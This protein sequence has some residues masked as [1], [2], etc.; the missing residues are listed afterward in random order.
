V[1]ALEDV[2]RRGAPVAGAAPHARVLLDAAGWAALAAEEAPALLA[3][4]PGQRSVHAALLD[5]AGRVVVAS[6]PAA[7]G[8]AALSP[9]RPGAAL[10]ERAARDLAGVVAEGAVDSRPWL[11]HAEETAWLPAEGHGLHRILAGPIHAGVTEPGQLRFTV[12]GEAVVR[13]EV[14]LGFTHKGTLSLMQGKPPWAAARFAARLS[15]DS[16]VAH[17]SAFAL[18]VEA[19]SGV[20]APPRAQALRVL[21][22]EWER[23]ANHL[24]DWGMICN[25]AG[26]AAIHAGTGRL[27]ETVLRAAEAAFGHRLMMDRVVPGGVAV[28]VS[29]EGVAALRSAALAVQRAMPG[30]QRV[31]ERHASL[32]DRLVGTGVIGAELVRRF[33]AGGVVGRASGRGFD[34][35]MLASPLPYAALSPRLVTRGEGDVAARLAVRI[36][37]L[38][39]SL[40]LVRAALDTLPDGPL[41]A[42]LPARA[43]EGSALVEGFRGECFAWVSLD[44]GGAIREVMLRDPSWLSWPLLEAAVQGNTVAE[45]PLIATSVNGSCAGCDL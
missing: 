15:G 14:R 35:R 12:Q 9:L 27:R 30:L 41:E 16:T 5:E 4:W 26:F 11:D 43:G 38:G 19:A 40:R 17:S 32:Q 22:L 23:V 2:L 34:A 29:G 20:V 3:L 7:P 36:E 13:M 21:M 37:E 39:E 31:L 28:D 44:D 6:G 45:V 18:A 1:S 10:F 24:Q 25:D 42:P 8:Y 33:A